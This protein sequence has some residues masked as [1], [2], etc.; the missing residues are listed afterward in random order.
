MQEVA[1]PLAPG[2]QSPCRK[3][4]SGEEANGQRPQGNSTCQPGRNQDLNQLLHLL[5]HYPNSSRA[6]PSWSPFFSI[7]ILKDREC[8][9]RSKR[10]F[11]LIP[12]KNKAIRNRATCQS[13]QGFHKPRWDTSKGSAG[14]SDADST[15][16]AAWPLQ[17]WSQSQPRIV[18][19]WC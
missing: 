5:H 13:A 17:T 10:T 8:S 16:G 1:T 3:E 19:Q 7:Q 12:Q 18:F 11:T 6:Q 15:S 4:A 9:R 2:R 14:H